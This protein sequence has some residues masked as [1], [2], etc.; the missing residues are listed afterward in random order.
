M[1]P[2]S[3][4][5]GPRNQNGRGGSQIFPSS[6]RLKNPIPS[7][8]KGFCEN[9]MYEYFFADCLVTGVLTS[10]E[11]CR[12]CHKQKGLLFDFDVTEQITSPFKLILHNV[13]NQPQSQW[14][15]T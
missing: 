15:Q 6:P 2:A 7:P 8:Q 10:A 12:P 4:T 13:L 14:L 11:Q 5:Q 9:Q 1:K 3:S